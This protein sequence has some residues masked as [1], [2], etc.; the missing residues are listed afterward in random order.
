MGETEEDDVCAGGG[1][2]EGGLGNGGPHIVEVLLLPDT[3]FDS[4]GMFYDASEMQ[5]QHTT[6]WDSESWYRESEIHPALYR[7]CSLISSPSSSH[8]RP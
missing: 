4:C 6:G 3:P 7:L 5:R 8:K 2:E 1:G